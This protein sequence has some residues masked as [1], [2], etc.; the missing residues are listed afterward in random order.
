MNWPVALQKMI[1][2]A[3]QMVGATLRL[4]DPSV[5]QI[6]VLLVTAS[7]RHW[8][9]VGMTRFFHIQAPPQLWRNSKKDCLS[10]VASVWRGV[11]ECLTL[12]ASSMDSVIVAGFPGGALYGMVECL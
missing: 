1:H 12:S 10:G 7:L 8:I 11:P 2:P 9:L 6:R 4:Y 3:V 5:T